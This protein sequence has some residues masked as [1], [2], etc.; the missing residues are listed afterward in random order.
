MKICGDN[1]NTNFHGGNVP[2]EKASHKCFSSI[3]LDSVTKSKKKYCTQTV[4]EECKYE[5]KYE[6]KK[7]KIENL[8]DN[9]FKKVHL[10]SLTMILVM[11]RNQWER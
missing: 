10:M 5:P 3:I 7:T 1:V 2:K 11:K 4:L 8:I 9:D 6:P